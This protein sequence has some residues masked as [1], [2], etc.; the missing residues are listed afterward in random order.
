[1]KKPLLFLLSLITI[2]LYNSSC[3]AVNLDSFII[4]PQYLSNGKVQVIGSP[5]T[6]LVD[7]A[8]SR[9][10]IPNTQTFESV[11]WTI[12]VLLK[13]NYTDNQVVISTPLT[14]T[15][16]DFNGS[17]FCNKTISA[18]VPANKFTSYTANGFVYNSKVFLEYSKNVLTG[19]S[20]GN[21]AYSINDYP[22]N[23]VKVSSPLT[24]SCCGIPLTPASVWNGQIYNPVY[25]GY[26][27]PIP[28]SQFYY[29]LP[30]VPAGYGFLDWIRAQTTH[31]F[32]NE[33]GTIINFNDAGPILTQGQTIYSPNNLYR[34]TLQTDGNLVLYSSSNVGLWNSQTQGTSALAFFFQSDLHLVLRNGYVHASP[35][36]WATGKYDLGGS[37]TR[38]AITNKIMAYPYLKLQDDGNLVLHWPNGVESTTGGPATPVII[39]FETTLSGAGAGGNGVSPVPGMLT[40][41]YEYSNSSDG[42]SGSALA[43]YFE[44]TH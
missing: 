8:L 16:T 15:S 32:N 43:N 41:P 22:V 27:V 44:I 11:N 29:N 5:Q 37:L 40:Y 18:L 33:A 23:L 13:D 38:F 6:I 1:M 39:I 10:L 42:N 7:I 24:S 20:T 26:P 9:S 35:S 3:F 2:I 25:D 21:P 12:T 28:V 30:G 19:I 17:A 4:E 36:I 34:L 31:P 14:V